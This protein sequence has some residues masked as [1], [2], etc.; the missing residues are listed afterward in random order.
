[1]AS[2]SGAPNLTSDTKALTEEAPS[3]VVTRV[4]PRSPSVL[5]AGCL[6]EWPRREPGEKFEIAVKYNLKR[7]SMIARI[8]AMNHH[9]SGERLKSFDPLQLITR[10]DLQNGKDQML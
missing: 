9:T 1:M 6:A 2:Y 3:A 5:G 7:K 4:R 10:S 8:R